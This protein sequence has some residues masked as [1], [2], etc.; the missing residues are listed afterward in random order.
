[1]DIKMVYLILLVMWWHL[2]VM[3]ATVWLALQ[4]ERV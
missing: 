1:M 3:N 4:K 2:V